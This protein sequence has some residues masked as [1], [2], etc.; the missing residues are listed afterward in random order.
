MNSIREKKNNVKL[1][2][3][4]E[5]KDDNTKETFQTK[6]ERKHWCKCLRRGYSSDPLYSREK[7]IPATDTG[8]I[9]EQFGEISSDATP[10]CDE[11]KIQK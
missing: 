5:D 3:V 10:L 11:K 1:H 6:C 8:K 7:G 4:K 9:E 2:G